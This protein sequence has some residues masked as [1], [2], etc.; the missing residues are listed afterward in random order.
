MRLRAHVHQIGGDAG[1]TALAVRAAAAL[2]RF[3]KV[4]VQAT[5]RRLEDMPFDLD[6]NQ[7]R[8]ESLNTNTTSQH[9]VT[10]PSLQ[11]GRKARLELNRR[12]VTVIALHKH[13]QVVRMQ[14]R[15]ARLRHSHAA[16]HCGS[17]DERDGG[18]CCWSTF[19]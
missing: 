15:G 16:V 18:G 13:F 2:L 17:A 11:L 8:V 12:A 9:E 1:Q 6:C 7:Y 4:L 19:L 5:D 3:G 14:N 10:H